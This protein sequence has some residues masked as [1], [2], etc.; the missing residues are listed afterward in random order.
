LQL[1]VNGHFARLRLVGR[2]TYYMGWL[3]LFSGALVHM[4]VGRPFFMT[5]SLTQRNLFEVSVVS[6]LICIA[7][8]LLLRE[9]AEGAVRRQAAA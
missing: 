2:A 9:P 6:F 5:I 3:T 8:E 1:E 7:S 4:N